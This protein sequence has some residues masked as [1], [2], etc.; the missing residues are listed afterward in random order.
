MN[1]TRVVPL[2]LHILNHNT[3]SWT[4]KDPNQANQGFH[5]ILDKSLKWQRI[6][7]GKERERRSLPS[8]R[9]WRS[10]PGLKTSDLR[11]VWGDPKGAPPPP[12]SVNRATSSEG[13]E[14][15]G[16]AG[17]MRLK[18]MCSAQAIGA[19]LYTVWRPCLRRC[20]AVCGAANWPGL[21]RW[22]DVRRLREGRCIVVCG[23]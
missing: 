20:T 9:D 10:N 6:Y 12:L 14:L 13:E 5:P 1:N 22:L 8:R 4:N 18:S 21:P 3:Q 17:P 19:A 2:W 23:A 7:G 16:G 15:L 11:G